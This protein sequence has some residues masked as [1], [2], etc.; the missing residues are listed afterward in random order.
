MPEDADQG[1]PIDLLI[2]GACPLARDPADLSR[3]REGGVT[4]CMP[5]VGGREGAGETLATLARMHRALRTCD[6]LL[7]VRGPADVR[8]AQASGRLGLLLHLRAPIR[9]ARDVRP[10]SNPRTVAAETVR[11]RAIRHHAHQPLRTK[12]IM[13]RIRHLRLV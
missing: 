11:S 7:L 3:H 13:A 6:E 1:A 9:Q 12:R 2:D 4:V 5:T 8:R 10:W